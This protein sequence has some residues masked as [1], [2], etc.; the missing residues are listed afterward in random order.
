MYDYY[1]DGKDNFPADRAAAE[2]A[3][4]SGLD[5]RVVA[6]EN[7]AFLNRVVRYLSSQAGIRQFLDIGTGIPISDSVHQLAQ[8][9][10]PETRV[11]YVDNDPIVLSHAR[12][13]PAPPTAGHTAYLD[14]DVRDPARILAGATKELDTEQPVAVLLLAVLHHVP[15]S[16]GPAAILRELLDGLPSG[17]YIALSHVTPEYAPAAVAR[18]AAAYERNGL[19]CEVRTRER[20]AE[21]LSGL[22]LVEPGIVPVSEW[23]PIGE[24]PRPT[25]AESSC[26]GM[27]ARKP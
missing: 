25:A 2:E 21:L 10:A 17:S 18:A 1:L 22:R 20:L 7:R 27:L 13:L 23:H 14:A 6:R 24:G 26:L 9:I 3:L 4:A 12:A 15:D 8:S 11:V 19:P 5:L 16:W